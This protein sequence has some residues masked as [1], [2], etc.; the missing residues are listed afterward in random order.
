MKLPP[1]ILSRCEIKASTVCWS[2]KICK[3][4]RISMA[5]YPTRLLWWFILVT[6]G[7]FLVTI[8]LQSDNCMVPFNILIWP[9][10]YHNRTA[11]LGY[12]EGLEV[13]IHIM[14]NLW[15][16][17]QN[18]HWGWVMLNFVSNWGCGWVILN[19]ETVFLI[20]VSDHDTENLH[21]PGVGKEAARCEVFFCSS[22]SLFVKPHSLRQANH[23]FNIVTSVKEPSWNYIWTES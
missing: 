12:P 4:G 22:E 8:R 18:W 1:L 19:F 20:Q 15:Q 5:R 16:Y 9:R 7:E 2:L 13:N 6:E 21:F 17:S 23:F 14:L 3:L 11:Y 10:L